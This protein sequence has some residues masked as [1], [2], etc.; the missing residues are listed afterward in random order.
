MAE[1]NTQD[2]AMEDILSSIKNILEEDQVNEQSVVEPNITTEDVDD[3]LELS[4]DMRLPDVDTLTQEINLDAELDEVKIPQLD[5]TE[6]SVSNENDVFNLDSSDDNSISELLSEPD[7]GFA[8]EVSIPTEITDITETKEFSTEDFSNSFQETENIVDN[9]EPAPILQPQEDVVAIAD[10]VIDD[11]AVNNVPIVEND[12]IETDVQEE[13]IPEPE[14][15]E[16]NENAVDASASIINNFAKMFA[17][18]EAAAQQQQNS[19]PATENKI[20]L[21]GDG[22]KTIEDVVCS[23]IKQII[24]DEVAANWQKFADYENFA[25]QEISLYTQK[26]IDK[27]LPSIVEKIVKQEIERVM[28]KAGRYQ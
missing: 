13:A 15:I 18:E 24:A 3:V 7:T 14:T 9:F 12:I 21:L 4:Q 27:N 5:I 22:S 20:N 28:A 11:V 1:E 16:N 8:E 23:V 10:Q 19:L 6:N 26:W 2:M 25:K 17:K